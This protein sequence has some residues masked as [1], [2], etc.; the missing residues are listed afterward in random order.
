MGVRESKLRH[1][2]AIGRLAKWGRIDRHFGWC[3]KQGGKGKHGSE[4]RGCQNGWMRHDDFF[5]IV[6]VP[7]VSETLGDRILN[8]LT[9]QPNP[10]DS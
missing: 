8:L 5:S 9:K 1:F 7:W 3:C 2:L 10:S 4:K 6:R